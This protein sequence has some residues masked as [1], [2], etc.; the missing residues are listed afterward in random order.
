M[1]GAGSGSPMTP[2]LTESYRKGSGV[3]GQ[4]TSGPHPAQLLPPGADLSDPVT[5]P[6]PLPEKA[7]LGAT[8]RKPRSPGRGHALGGGTQQP[9]MPAEPGSFS[10]GNALH[11]SPQVVH[12]VEGR[13]VLEGTK[14][15][16]PSTVVYARL[17]LGKAHGRQREPEQWV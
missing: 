14:S 5:K 13:R 8:G 4:G 7:T 10:C 2:M 12:R 11:L 15:S 17:I 6:R 1:D 9:L 16:P 3:L